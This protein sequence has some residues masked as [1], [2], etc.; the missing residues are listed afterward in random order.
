MADCRSPTKTSRQ[1]SALIKLNQRTVHGSSERVDIKA[2][3][4]NQTDLI[5]DS[6]HHTQL[7]WF[8]LGIELHPGLLQNPSFDTLQKWA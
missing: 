2:E 3:I 8:S 5:A 4:R 1:V 6:L 7:A